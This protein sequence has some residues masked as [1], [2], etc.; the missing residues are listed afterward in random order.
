MS[1]LSQLSSQVGD[2]TEYSNRKVV[3]QVLDEPTL[4]EDI[5]AGLDDKDAALV[6]DCAEVLTQV[7]ETRPDWVA[8]HAKKLGGLLDH[9][10][11]RVRWEAM[12]AL[13]LV[14]P[15]APKVI[16]PLLPR[17][18]ELIRNDASVIV[19]DYAVDAI[20]NYAKT[21]R[22]AAQ[23]SYPYLKQAL[24]VWD[25]KQAG[26]ALNGLTIVAAVAPK[27][28]SELNAIGRQ[29]LEHRRGVV[30]QAA[31]KLVQTTENM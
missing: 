12:H 16:G 11:T 9:R 31:K 28:A 17:L 13:A 8:P 21:S 2:R 14:A 5:V 6:G 4:L 29:H 27:L 24:T 23:A 15:L 1:I 30:R 25:G 26:H 10:K 3:L 19:R 22:K 7:A 18:G 20:A